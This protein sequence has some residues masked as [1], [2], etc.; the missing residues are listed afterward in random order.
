MKVTVTKIMMSHCIET[1]RYI[2]PKKHLSGNCVVHTVKAIISCL[3]QI[4]GNIYL[5]ESADL[6][7]INS[8]EEDCLIEG[9]NEEDCAWFEVCFKRCRRY[10]PKL[11]LKD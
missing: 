4:F 11:N 1:S 2:Q 8:D 10:R 7:N 9:M 6:V 3:E 5:R